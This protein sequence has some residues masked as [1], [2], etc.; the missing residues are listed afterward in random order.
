MA[1]ERI[2]SRFSWATRSRVSAA[3]DPARRRDGRP[4]GRPDEATFTLSLMMPTS[5]CFTRVDGPSRAVKLNL[6]TTVEAVLEHL[7]APG[8]ASHE[9]L[10]PLTCRPCPTM[11]AARSD[12]R[13]TM[14]SAISWGDAY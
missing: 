7:Q 12:A 9:K 6:G 11:W 10:P 14:T 2:R 13:K 1:A 8:E 3:G 4:A 5:S